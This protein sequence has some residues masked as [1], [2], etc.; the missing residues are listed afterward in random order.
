MAP[1]IDR[2]KVRKCILDQTIETSKF[3]LEIKV[4]LGMESTHP[5]E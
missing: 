1:I 4:M 3:A 2:V 5:D